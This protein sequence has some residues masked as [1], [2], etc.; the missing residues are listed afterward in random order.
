MLLVRYGYRCQVREMSQGPVCGGYYSICPFACILRDWY[1]YNTEA[2]S[3]RNTEC[4]K[5]RATGVQ[6]DPTR[7][8]MIGIGPEGL[9]IYTASPYAYRKAAMLVNLEFVSSPQGLVC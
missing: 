5:T 7:L 9:L 1:N 4:C 6:L 8:I 2:V 3:A